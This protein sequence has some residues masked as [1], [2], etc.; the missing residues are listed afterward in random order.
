M[1]MSVTVDAGLSPKIEN[2]L[3]GRDIDYEVEVVRTKKRT[4][5]K[6]IARFPPDDRGNHQAELYGRFLERIRKGGA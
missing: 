4:Y 1:K 2:W 6:I 5:L 3:I